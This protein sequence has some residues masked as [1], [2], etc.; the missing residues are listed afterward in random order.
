MCRAGRKIN[1]VQI[2]RSFAEDAYAIAR[3]AEATAVA[4]IDAASPRVRKILDGKRTAVATVC[5]AICGFVDGFFTA[6]QNGARRFE[7]DLLA[8]APTAQGRGIGGKLVAASLAAAEDG[9]ARLCRALVR[10]ENATMRK[11]CQLHGFHRSADSHALYLRDAQPAAAWPR[12][13]VSHL[14]PVDTLGYAG[15]WIEGHL[16]QAAVDAA[17]RLASIGGA[18]LVGAVI[19]GV[20]VESAALLAANSFRIVGQYHWWT[21]NLR[22]D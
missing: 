5:G 4:S 16:S 12:Q 11:L 21:I 17:A 13:H 7:L 14:L 19:P 1:A 22:N 18:S 15:I 10:R 8:V 9:G 3:I 20:D 6:D 2:R